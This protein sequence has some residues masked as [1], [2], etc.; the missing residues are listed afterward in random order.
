L[1]ETGGMEVFSDILLIGYIQL[2]VALKSLSLYVIVLILVEI[3]PAG[4]NP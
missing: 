2:P 3:K 4:M 1:E